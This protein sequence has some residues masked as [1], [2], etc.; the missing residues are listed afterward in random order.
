MFDHTILR[1]SGLI[2]QLEEFH[3][4]RAWAKEHIA[5][6]IHAIAVLKAAGKVD[7]ENALLLLDYITTSRLRRSGLKEFVEALLEKRS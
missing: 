5:D 3:K 4:N 2:S 7:R 6:M 1:L